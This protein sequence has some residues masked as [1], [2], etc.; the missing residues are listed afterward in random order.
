MAETSNGQCLHVKTLLED[1]KLI[2]KYKSVLS[3]STYRKSRDNAAKRR[4]VIAAYSVSISR[5]TELDSFQYQP[6]R[7]VIILWHGRWSA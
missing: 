5:L 4:K 7:R 1:P 6:V 3:W 2:D